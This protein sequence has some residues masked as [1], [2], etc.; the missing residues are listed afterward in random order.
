MI[1]EKTGSVSLKGILTAKQSAPW[2]RCGGVTAHHKQGQHD[3]SCNKPAAAAV[4]ILQL[5]GLK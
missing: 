2:P 1:W 5:K 4:G 3:S